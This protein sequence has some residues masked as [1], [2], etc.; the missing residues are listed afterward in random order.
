MIALLVPPGALQDGA[1]VVL[2][3]AEVHHARVRR[4]EALEVVR[5]MDGEGAMA[6]AR[7]LKDKRG[8]VA[9]V[10][11][12]WRVTAPVRVILAVGAG[13]RD[14]FALVVEKAA[15]LGATDVIPLQTGH[16][17]AVAA[18][19]RA[20]HSEGFQRRAREAI[21]QCGSA[22]AVRVQ[23]PVTLRDFLAAPRVGTGW[24]A[25]AAGIPAPAL[26]PDEALEIVIGP[27]AGF[28]A[29]ERGAIV[30]AGFRPVGLGP[31][32]LRFETAA[33]A[34]LAVQWHARQGRPA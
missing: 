34:A 23:E 10:L 9:E 22:W 4:A 27:E 25:D 31:H 20:R 3:E 17:G 11:S 21:K 8:L 19:T 18:R 1:M 30:A 6:E 28:T 14:R 26:A 15:E 24:L 13:E 12:V 2:Q 29:E 5:L 33:I 7:L 16:S 32:V